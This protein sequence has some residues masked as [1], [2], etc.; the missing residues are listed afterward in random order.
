MRL[1][2]IRTM[3]AASLFLGVSGCV[4]HYNEF[5][6]WADAIPVGT[7]VSKVKALQPN[8]VTIDWR[9]PVG[10]DTIKYMV[11]RIRGSVD[12]I[13]MQHELVFTKRG[14]IARWPHK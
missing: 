9:H 4:N 2:R 14:Y 7:P 11:T 3:I 13:K 8:Y 5:V 6:N 12:P 10:I 1:E